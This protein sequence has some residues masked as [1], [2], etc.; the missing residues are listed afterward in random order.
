MKGYLTLAGALAGG[1]AKGWKGAALGAGV[2][3][4]LGTLLEQSRESRERGGAEIAWVGA[5]HPEESIL[6]AMRE[7]EDSSAEGEEMESFYR[8]VVGSHPAGLA[9]AEEKSGGREGGSE[10]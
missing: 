9:A 7:A 1:L 8:E 2:G 6:E 4:G 10:D 5:C 3:F